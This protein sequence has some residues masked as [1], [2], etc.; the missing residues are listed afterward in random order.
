[1]GPLHRFGDRRGSGA[2]GDGEANQTR[3]THLSEFC[4]LF[5]LEYCTGS[6]VLKER[7]RE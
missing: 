7:E 1:M 6:Q 4:N 5:G 2:D 3:V